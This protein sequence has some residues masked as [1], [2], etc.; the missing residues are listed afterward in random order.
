MADI[1]VSYSRLDQERVKP[2]VDRLGSLGYS[3]WWAPRERADAAAVQEVEAQLDQAKAV[4]TLWSANA[5]N[6]S[7]VHAEA[8]RAFDAGKLAQA[9]LDAI[10]APLPFG[11]APAAD[12]SGARGEWGP[13]EDTLA[14]IVR[15]APP[16][17]ADVPTLGPLATP[18]VTGAPKLIA[19]AIGAT[20]T[21][22]GGAVSAAADGVMSPDQLQLALTPMLGVG[23]V[24][25]TLSAYRLITVSRAGG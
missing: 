25:A 17:L 16:P 11:A 12:L 22:F 5:R 14:R 4:L 21:A 3:V 23:L 1:F 8:A 7:W 18:A 2:I 6:S 15:S 24:C 10:D 9:R 20:L 19:F 13:L